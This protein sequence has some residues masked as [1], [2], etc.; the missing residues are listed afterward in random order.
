MTQREKKKMHKLEGRLGLNVQ[1]QYKDIAHDRKKMKKILN[2]VRA[3]FFSLTCWI[4]KNILNKVKKKDFKSVSVFFFF[5][6]KSREK[7]LSHMFQATDSTCSTCSVSQFLTPT[8]PPS[9][10][11]KCPFTL[12]LHY[13]FFFLR[14][15][16]PQCE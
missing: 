16:Q 8:E 5:Y 14:F 9:M 13:S 4:K 10:C 15:K 2:C 1:N 7:Q 11:L 12:S 6:L 3:D